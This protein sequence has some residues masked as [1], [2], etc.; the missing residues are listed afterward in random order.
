MSDGAAQLYAWL[1]RDVVPPPRRALF[2]AVVATH[3]QR[4]YRLFHRDF[5]LASG[6]TPLVDAVQR[7]LHR[8]LDE[9]TREPFAFYF[10]VN[11][12]ANGTCALV[13]AARRVQYE[14]DHAET[15]HTLTLLTLLHRDDVDVTTRDDAGE[16]PLSTLVAMRHRGI[17][18]PHVLAHCIRRLQERA[19]DGAWRR[20]RA[21]FEARQ[22]AYL[23]RAHADTQ[24][25]YL[26]P[27]RS[28]GDDEEQR[29]DEAD[30]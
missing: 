19:V 1:E 7:G 15:N 4:F 17:E 26:L 28:S 3:R 14:L 22:R 16:T 24:P 20:R 10:D 27:A 11:A 21:D 23:W 18:A 6:D 9:A 2:N 5:R 30:T 12:H 25:L 29:D 8:F 13:L